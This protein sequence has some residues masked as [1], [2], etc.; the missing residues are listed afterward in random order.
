V[1]PLIGGLLSDRA[2][3]RSL[4]QSTSYLPPKA[5]LLGLV[6][7]AGFTRA[8]RRALLFGAV[9]IVTATRRDTP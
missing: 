1:V 8:A 5:E 4:P 3:Y 7:R 9:Q 2:A 6:E